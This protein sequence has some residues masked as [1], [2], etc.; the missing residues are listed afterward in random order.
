MPK[1]LNYSLTKDDTLLVKGVAICLMLCHHLF[2]DEFGNVVFQTA[3]FGK[4]CVALFLF[5]SSYGLS[6]QYNTIQYNTIQ[7]NTIP[8]PLLMQ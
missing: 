4:V 7:Y 6:I 2:N 1:S 3:Q 5:V 8:F